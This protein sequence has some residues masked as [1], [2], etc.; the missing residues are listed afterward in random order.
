MD[1][2][3]IALRRN[4]HPI[5]SARAAEGLVDA[6]GDVRQAWLAD[7][8]AVKSVIPGAAVEWVRQKAPHTRRRG[9]TGG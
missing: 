5:E 2:W 6:P 1:I 7:V 8:I 4:T 3:S 9:A